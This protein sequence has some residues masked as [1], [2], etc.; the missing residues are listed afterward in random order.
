MVRKSIFKKNKKGWIKILEAFIAVVFLISILVLI[1]ND[2]KYE[3]NEVSNVIK[4]QNAFLTLI[5][6]NDILR[7]D[8]LAVDTSQRFYE[9]NDTEFP[10]SLRNYIN[11]SFSGGVECNAKICNSTA[12]C[13]LIDDPENEVFSSAIIITSNLTTFNPKKLSVFC[14]RI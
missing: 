11:E 4:T 9:M 8:I 2:E 12:E 7:N 5:Q 1:I 6:K 10:E 3:A 14:W 13:Y